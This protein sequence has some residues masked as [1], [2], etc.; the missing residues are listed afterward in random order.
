MAVPKPGQG[1]DL[2]QA[3]LGG[4]AIAGGAALCVA[5]CAELAAGAAVFGAT[6]WAGEGIG[7][8]LTAACI[9]ACAA[10]TTT[11]QAACI[12]SG[13]CVGGELPTPGATTGAGSG[14][15]VRFRVPQWATPEEIA[16]AQAYVD[17]GNRGVASGQLSPGGRVPTAGAIA[18]EARAT[19]IA[20]RLRANNAGQPYNGVVGHGP[21][22]TWTGTGQALE[23]IDM[24]LR[25]N[26]SLAGQSSH[27]PVAYRPTMFELMAGDQ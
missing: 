12:A 3:V 14:G 21:D 8:A 18:A 4:L 22:S 13:S 15:P 2:G 20:E 10:A 7:A 25:M 26:S 19:A 9:A 11:A 23:W 16:Q 24:T 5:V 1:M 27:Y 17:A 6:V